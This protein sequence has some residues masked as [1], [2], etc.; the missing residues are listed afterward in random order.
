MMRSSLRI[1]VTDYRKSGAGGSRLRHRLG[2]EV[3][4]KDDGRRRGVEPLLADAPVLLAHGQPA[5]RFVAG[6][7]LVLQRAPAATAARASRAAKACTRGVMSFGRAVE[8][9]RQADDDRARRRPLRRR[10]AR[11]RRDAVRRAS[12]SRPVVWSDADAAAPACRCD[13]SRR[14][15]CGARPRPARRFARMRIILAFSMP[16]EASR[17][18]RSPVA[19]VRGL[20][21]GRLTP[22]SSPSLIAAGAAAQSPALPDARRAG[23]AR[24]RAHP[25]P[26]GRSR[27]AGRRGAARSSAICARSRSSATC[28]V[29]SCQPPSRR[30]RGP[31]RARGHERT[32]C[33]RS[34]RSASAQLPDLQA[35][36]VDIYKRGRAGYARL[37]FGAERRARRSRAPRGRSPR[38]RPSTRG[39]SPS[40][41][42]RWRRCARERAAL[43]QT[44]RRA[45]RRA[46][47]RPGG[48]RAAADR[49]VRRGRR[50]STRID[51]RRDLT[52]QY[53]GELQAAHDR[54]QQQVASLGAPG[55]AAPVVLCR[56]APV[57]RRARLAG[58]RAPVTGPLR[59]RRR[60]RLGGTVVRNG[61]EIAAAGR[62]HPSGPC[63]RGTVGYAEPFAGFG[64]LVIVDHG[65]NNFSLYG[66]LARRRGR[67]RAV[68]TGR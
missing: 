47:P 8:P 39:E 1:S 59:R 10:G 25:R 58:R 67:G 11:S 48:A 60:G 7:P 49:A 54:L 61:I 17:P 27:A 52:A 32:A 50:S 18:A 33:Q 2:I 56:S 53:V 65:G 57:P 19:A 35:Q 62:R 20:R 34:R 14:R 63:M 42:G 12:P 30:C 6:Q 43:E 46:T 41:G 55:G 51:S 9:P 4:L 36:L 26:A 40:T 31:S 28:A 15:R 22:S 29:R 21:A 5:L 13:R 3:V 38:W 44:A 66:Y 37:L 64:T 45:A 16:P 24:R 68:Q 23:S